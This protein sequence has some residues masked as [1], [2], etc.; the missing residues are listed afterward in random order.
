MP[1]YNKRDILDGKVAAWRA[2]RER[3]LDQQF[4]DRMVRVREVPPRLLEAIFAEPRPM[5]PTDGQLD[6]AHLLAQG[7]QSP[8]VAHRLGLSV[9]TVRTQMK[10]LQKRLLAKNSTHSVAILIRAGLI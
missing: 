2:A 9:E 6:I 10:N 4:C 1:S 8:E 7:L 3:G 5:I